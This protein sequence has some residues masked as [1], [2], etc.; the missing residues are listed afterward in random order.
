MVS[1][2]SSLS[3]NTQLVKLL[4][5]S[6]ASLQ[7]K[8]VQIASGKT[9]QDYTGLAQNSERLISIEN[10][11]AVLN[12]FVSTNELM[13]LRLKISGSSLDGLDK[14]LNGFRK[15]LNIFQTTSKTDTLDV[16]DVQNSAFLA[17]QT[18]ESYLNTEVNGQF[19]YSGGRVTTKPVDFGLTNLSDLQTKWDGANVTYPT[20][21]D[22]AVHPKMT[23]GTGFPSNPTGAGFTALN[24]T[25]GTGAAGQIATTNIATQVDTITIAGSVAAGDKYSVTVNG[26]KVTYTVTGLEADINAIRDNLFAAVNANA[27]TGA[28]VTAAAGGAGELT[29]TSKTAGTAFTALA[30]STNRTAIAQVDNA[31]LTG[32]FA[33]GESVSVNVNGLGA[34]SYAVIANDLTL[35]GDGTGGAVAGNSAA[36]YNNITTKLAAAINANAPSAAIVTAAATGG[37]GGVVTL[38]AV[39]AGTAFT[40]VT[41]DTAAAGTATGSTVTAN[42]SASTSNKATV[43]ITTAN[44]NAFANIP[45]GSTITITGADTTANNGT[46][47]VTTNS[48]GIIS[49]GATET[50][51]TTVTPDANVAGDALTLTSNASYYSGDEVTQTHNVNETRSFNVDLTALDPA[52]EKAIRGLFIIA[53]GKFQTAGGLDQ[54][55]S[56]VADVKY[57]IDSALERNPGGTAPYGTELTSSLDQITRDVGF[58]RVLIKQTNEINNSLINFY[59]KKISDFE[60]I[61]PT[62]VYTALLDEQSALEASY[63]ALARIRQLSL[64][65]FL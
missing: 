35:N 41:A 31:T 13:D 8:Q 7:N 20:Y 11:R 10:S 45:V 60:D 42:L 43:V 15:D 23:A 51:A 40:Q 44:A 24:F 48:A 28:A 19:L 59:D 56:R 33:L 38:T 30:D 54:N 29:L 62:A 65:Q 49:I 58:D 52:F 47:T 36:A 55:T 3:S 22:N 34:V 39:T 37:G 32:T 5:Q 18:V 46:Y 27:T 64:V 16:R 6:Q 2:I 61:D 17:L 9:S 63:S 12:N 53:Q 14:A 4:L 57:L 25:A 1:R 21:R 50:I 26:T